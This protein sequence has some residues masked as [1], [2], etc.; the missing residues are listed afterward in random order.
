[1]ITFI[2]PPNWMGK[3]SVER[4]FGCNLTIYPFP[5]I[6]LLI[7]ASILENNNYKVQF[8][9]AACE[10]WNKKKFE[11]FLINDNS[12]TYI[13]HSVNLSQKS[14][15]LTL[16]LIRNIKKEASII[17]T[18]PAPTL[19][20]EEFILDENVYVIRG[21]PELIIEK[22]LKSIKNSKFEIESINGISYMS[23][24]SIFHN[25]PALIVENIDSLPYPARHLIKNPTAYF[26]PKLPFTPWTVMLTSRG[27]SFECIFCV[28]CSLSFAREIEY[29]KE[30][31]HKPPVRMRS[32]QNIIGEFTLLKKQGYKSVSIIDDQFIWNKERTLE[33]CEGIKYF[34]IKW[35]CLSRADFIHEEIIEKMKE[36]GCE[37][38]DLGVESF[39]QETLD[40][41]KKNIRVEDIYNAIDIL[42]KNRIDVKLNILFGASPFETEEMILNNLKIIKKIKPNA[43]MFSIAS[44]FPGTNFYEMAK[45]NNWFDKKDYEPVYVQQKAIISYPSISSEK[46]EKLIKK[47]TFSFYLNPFY[48][49]KNITKIT[50]FKSLVEAI[51]STL[52]KLSFRQ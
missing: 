23:G 44:P 14:D 3:R 34:G 36:A 15:L 40:F 24:N 42:K 8:V 20:P 47:A 9:D 35:G 52:R 49:A 38:V 1:M 2:E 6:F 48:I 46:L 22:L 43:V 45:E 30:H 5:N 12:S 50:S 17:F 29:K 33:I 7:M 18:G 32:A 31:G 19:K 37:Y 27:C 51:K 25:Q 39:N 16:K 28:P 41:V 4:V 11:K 13:I 10:N 21:E 26:S